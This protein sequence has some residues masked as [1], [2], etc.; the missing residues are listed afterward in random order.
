[1]TGVQTCALPICFNLQHVETL[2]TN[3]LFDIPEPII[4]GMLARYHPVK[5]Q[6]TLLKAA[7][8]LAR[9]RPA[10][11][12]L[13]IG[14]V[15][16]GYEDYRAEMVRFIS[17]HG[18]EQIVMLVNTVHEEV[19]AML[20]GIDIFA[21]PSLTESFSYSLLA[22]MA[23][24]RPVITTPV[25]GNLEIITNRENGMF[26]PPDDWQALASAIETLIDD[27]A[28]RSRLGKNARQTIENNWS[29]DIM[30]TRTQRVYKQVLE[31]RNNGR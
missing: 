31:A 20:A 1:M 11:R 10:C 23:M 29:L 30:L 7:A 17:E 6:L 21:A 9:S 5:G 25:G 14:D 3:N 2:L 12:F 16:P 19:P 26:I 24:Q 8:E 28:R 27:P 15:M 4:I 22:A 18:L 13:L